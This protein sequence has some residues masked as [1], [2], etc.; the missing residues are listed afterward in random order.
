MTRIA[1][2]SGGIQPLPAVNGGAAEALSEYL[3]EGFCQD[4][5]EVSIYTI[6]DKKLENLK[7][8]KY[9]I[10]SFKYNYIEK[11]ISRIITKIFTIL[12]INKAYFIYNKKVIKE[13]KKHDYDM[14]I[15]E[16][17]LDIYR[18]L[19]DK[20]LKDKN[21]KI[22]FHLHNKVGMSKRIKYNYNLALKTC[23]S[24]IVVSN[25]FKKY[26]ENICPL[27]SNKIKVLYN[28]V[29]ENLISNYKFASREMLM[30][31]YN[32]TQNDKIFLYSGRISE[33][34][35]VLE[36]IKAFNILCNKYKNIK[37]LVVGSVNFGK[38]KKNGYAKLITQT[39]NSSNIIFTGYIE[40]EKI[41]DFYDLADCVVVPSTGDEAFGCVL[42]EAMAMK[43]TIIATNSGG[44]P[45]ILLE[46]FAIIVSKENLI[47]D[48]VVAVEKMA[49]DNDTKKMGEKA[50]KYYMD[51]DLFFSSNYYN[52]FKKVIMDKGCNIN[53]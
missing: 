32:L 20:Y 35:G 28:C 13:I 27:Y 10:Y 8:K 9:H 53:E 19:Y 34:K 1:F 23:D 37:L 47:N 15:I 24:F 26:V 14:V 51:N 33:E 6:Y 52:N 22:I 30:S 29:N 4:N 7:N 11:L 40:K 21:I 39:V 44:M 49:F 2:V 41:Y 43:K 18:D 46:D 48:L 45:E 12:K 50:H 17:S 31:K 5:C 25:F 36:L 3:I 16:N 38:N 42:L